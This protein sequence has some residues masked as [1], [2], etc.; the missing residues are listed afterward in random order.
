MKSMGSM[1]LNA[2]PFSELVMGNTALVRGMLEAGVRVATSY[3]GSPTPEIAAAILSIA[4]EQRPLHFEFCVNEK[5]A[6]EVAYGAAV[7]G[8][9]AVSFFKSVGLNVAS[10]TFVQ[11]NHMDIPG[12]MVV[13]VGDDPG[14]H[15][16][17]NEQDNR[18]LARMSYTPVLEPAT[19]TEVYGYFLE[20]AALARAH[21]MAVML[22]LT[23]HVCHA[24]EMVSFAGWTP[25]P[26]GEQNAGPIFDGSG[27]KY[28]PIGPMVARMKK[29]ALGRLEA[30]A[31]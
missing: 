20:A 18:H 29:R 23:T 7:N 17:Q 13:V 4:P 5:V 30:V 3:P 27:G 6:V 21:H 25:N 16:S 1:L 11:L 8:N 9:L 31:G 28:I 22:R 24:K 12:G 26:A 2:G 14:A 10:D 19:P 15:S